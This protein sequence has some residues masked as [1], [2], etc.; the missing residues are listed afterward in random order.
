MKEPILIT[1]FLL[2]IVNGFAQFNDTYQTPAVYKQNQ[3]KARVM[4]FD[5]S[6][7]KGRVMVEYFDHDGYTIEE[8]RYDTLGEKFISRELL[9]YDSVHKII[10]QVI[11]YYS[12]YDTAQKKYLYS[13]IPDTVNI[14]NEYDS[15]KRW[16]KQTHINKEGRVI[17]Q[18]TLTYDPLTQRNILIAVTAV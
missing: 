2:C 5:R 6:R 12:Q 3:V 15:L 16:I 11:Y 14:F 7:V 10:R 9:S 1:V 18:V 8:D 13:A 4:M 17:N